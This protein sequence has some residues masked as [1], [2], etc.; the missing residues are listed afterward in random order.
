MTFGQCLCFCCTAWLQN[1][2][3]IAEVELTALGLGCSMK[4]MK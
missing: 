4:E 2:Q 3:I 1:I